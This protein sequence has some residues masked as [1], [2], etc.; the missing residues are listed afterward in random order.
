MF[1]INL[2]IPL[3]KISDLRF[4]GCLKQPR[5]TIIGQWNIPKI[6][7]HFDFPVILGKFKLF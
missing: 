2:S 3:T 6:V 4:R 7:Y 1:R 5:P